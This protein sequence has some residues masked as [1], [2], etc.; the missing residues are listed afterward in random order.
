MIPSIFLLL[1]A[2]I[3]FVF[4]VDAFSGGK[5]FK[6][7]RNKAVKKSVQFGQALEDPVAEAEAQIL[8][9][10][11]KLAEA[12]AFLTKVKAE[13]N[14][15]LQKAKASR[16]DADKMEECAKLAGKENNLADVK[17]ALE[18]KQAAS[19][20]AATFEKSVAA[21][22]ERISKAQTFI[23]A[24]QRTLEELER[25]KTVHAVTIESNDKMA[26]LDKAMAE[27]TAD[28]GEIGGLSKL[29]EAAIRS[30]ATRD[31][32]L[33]EASG[34]TSSLLSKYSA[35]DNSVSDEEARSYL[36]A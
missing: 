21:L 5:V 10:R 27:L 36:A 34:S 16:A 22:D 7:L 33:E 26:E 24:R 18:K 15:L 8:D 3:T 17:R 28:S 1:I 9:G 11:Q 14:V 31:A 35:E 32:K 23:D 19:S 6:G 29:E 13:K 2:L 25:N 12:Q 30:D 4:L 20:L